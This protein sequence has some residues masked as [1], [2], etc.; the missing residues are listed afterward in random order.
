MRL[1]SFTTNDNRRG[2]GV[3]TEDGVRVLSTVAAADA[4]AGFSP[5]RALLVAHGSNLA[6]LED[7]LADKELIA[8]AAV[9]LD[10]PVPDPGKVIAAPVNYRDHQA[11]MNQD[12][13]IDALGVFLKAPSS[14]VQN[15]STV[16]L[17]YTDRRID[18]EGELA[19]VIGK[20]AS[21]VSAAEALD[22]VAGYTML[23]DIT[24]R[25]GEDRSTRK[26]FDTFTPM[27]PFLVTPDEVG[28]LDALELRTWVSGTLRQHAR[29]A[30]LIWGVPELV[31]YASS[32]MAL[33]PGDVI[34]TGTPA[35]VG[36]IHEGD[37]IVVEVGGVG[38]LAVTVSAA[39]AI[40]CPTRGAG[41]GPK[42]P[43]EL[44]PVQ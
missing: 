13:H 2:V 28:P 20:R 16:R 17:P 21:N 37:D 4:D 39:G 7:Q 23:L 43:E 25:G 6:Q 30:D 26:S 19:L 32:V 44:T 22:Y 33:Q 1:L 38:R 34:T 5:M 15:E 18:Q 29:I 31:A 14:V 8:L 41:R 3:L 24:M 27:G 40:A 11:E 10:A 9:T 42:P 35:G 12:A 36:R